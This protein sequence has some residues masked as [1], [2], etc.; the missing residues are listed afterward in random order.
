MNP[1]FHQQQEQLRKQQEELRRR[2]Q[3]AVFYEQQK[4][5]KEQQSKPNSYGFP[6]PISQQIFINYRRDDTAYAAGRLY[7]RLSEHFGKSNVFMDIDAIELGVNFRERIED[8]VGHCDVLIVMIGKQWLNIKNERGHRRLDEPNDFV[9]LEIMAAL[10]RGIHVIPILIDGACMPSL[11]ELPGDLSPLSER[12]GL[13]I[14][15][16]HF[17][18]DAN[19]LINGIESILSPI[20]A[21]AYPRVQATTTT[22]SM[23]EA[24]NVGDKKGSPSCLASALRGLVIGSISGV[25]MGVLTS[26]MYGRVDVLD[27]A[28]ALLVNI[29]GGVTISF[30]GV[31]KW[32]PI[33]I[34]M[35]L[36]FVL[37]WTYNLNNTNYIPQRIATSLILGCVLGA[38][39]G[40]IVSRVFSG[41]R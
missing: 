25:I 18:D 19:R 3:M 28:I 16:S 26:A 12:N 13:E 2:Q 34:G 4:G 32:A 8:A 5:K 37:L 29:L 1:Q 40:A 39:L 36:G 9:R 21:S 24:D 17:T 27:W 23:E 7:D 31:R 15:H 38:V 33:L 35:V 20:Q 6:Q 11:T 14:R 22:T 30:I 10:Q 41:R